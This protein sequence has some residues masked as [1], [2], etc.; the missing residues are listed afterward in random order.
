MDLGKNLEIWIFQG[1]VFCNFGFGLR[2][3]LGN[4]DFPEGGVFCNFGFGLREKLGNLD[5]PEGGVFCNFGFGLREKLGNLDFP[6]GGVFCNFGFGLR[7]KLGNLDFPEGRGG[8]SATSDLDLGKNL[9]IWIFQRGGGGYSV[10]VMEK[11]KNQNNIKIL[12]STQSR[13]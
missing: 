4:L 8:Y 5:F 9:E 1:G 10:N 6:E 13:G 3:K 12:L 7:E 11:E 2:E